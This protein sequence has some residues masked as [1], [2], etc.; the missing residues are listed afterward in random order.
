M[1]YRKITTVYK[2][3]MGSIQTHKHSVR[4]ERR[5]FG[6]FL[7]LQNVNISF[8][9][10][11]CPPGVTPSAWNNM[12]PTKRIFVEFDMRI[13]RKSVEVFHFSL[14]SDNNEYFTWRPAYI[15]NNIPLNSSHNVKCFRKSCGENQ[16]THFTFNKVFS[17]NRV[18]Y[19]IMWK[20]NVERGRLQMTIWC[21][22]IAWWIPKATHAFSEYVILIAFRRCNG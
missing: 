15:Y 2:I 10:S 3:I 8:V 4:R 11:V 19:E 22:R 12:A 7:K 1:L 17:E 21:M 20:N 5:V 9:M 16:T 6:A 14:K 18:I 13:F